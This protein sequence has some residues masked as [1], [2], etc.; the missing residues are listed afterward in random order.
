MG[1]INIL[2]IESWLNIPNY[3]GI[4]IVSNFGNV[5]CLRKNKRRSLS[6]RISP[7]GYLRVTLHKESN[8]R[9]YFIHQL[10]AM[11]FLGHIPNGNALV[12][13]HKNFDKL[14]NN[15]DN[16][17]IVT[18]R[19]NSN[20]KHLKSTSNFVGVDYHKKSK[21]FRSRIVYKKKLIHLGFYD[22]EILASVAYENKL[23]EILHNES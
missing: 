23:K 18:N 10:V 14:N 9:T 16:L 3:E 17:E 20:R 22:S 21:K 11:A 13:N 8:R 15:I 19:E 7:S 2:N 12:I 6:K 5:I 1:D 4:Y